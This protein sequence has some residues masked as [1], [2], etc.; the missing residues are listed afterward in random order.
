MLIP[1][2]SL[3]PAWRAGLSP[4]DVVPVQLRMLE[5]SYSRLVLEDQARIMGIPGGTRMI[6]ER[7]ATP[8][9]IDRMGVHG[10]QF[11]HVGEQAAFYARHR[12]PM[13]E[14][15]DLSG[16]VPTWIAY[17]RTFEDK[18]AQDPVRPH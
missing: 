18:F 14:L 12:R 16:W 1:Y 11:D 2:G 17:N 4:D 5:P 6:V 3:F 9:L 13:W 15:P 8:Y 10:D 7:F